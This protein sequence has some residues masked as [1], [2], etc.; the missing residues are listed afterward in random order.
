MS[1]PTDQDFRNAGVT[2]AARNYPL[3]PAGQRWLAEWN[4]TT[5]EKMPDAW[6]YAPN[7]AMRD[8]IERSAKAKYGENSE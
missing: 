4:G 2:G 8:K 1:E 5:V 3:T 7:P 6:R